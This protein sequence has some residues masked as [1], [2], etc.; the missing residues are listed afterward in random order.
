MVQPE[1]RQPRRTKPQETSHNARLRE[2]KLL[3]RE[4]T[5]EISVSMTH[6][7]R[8]NVESRIKIT[9]DAAISCVPLIISLFRAGS[10]EA[11]GLFRTDLSGWKDLEKS[12]KEQNK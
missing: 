12:G 8:D 3:L 7:H 5:S 1:S 4:E 2:C 11:L 10:I 6:L 9:Q